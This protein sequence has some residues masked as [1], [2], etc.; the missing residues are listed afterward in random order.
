MLKIYLVVGLLLVHIPVGAITLEERIEN[1]SRNEM[2][3]VIEFL[4]HDLL[5]GRSPGT[6]GG[7]LAEAYIKSL[8][9]L[10]GLAPGFASSYLQPLHLLAFE[11]ETMRAEAGSVSLLYGKNLVGSYTGKNTRYTHRADAVFVG[12]GIQ[13]EP[14][15]WDDFKDFDVR[16]KIIIVRVNDPGMHDPSIFEGKTLTYYGRWTYHVQE[17]ARRGASGILLIHTDESAGY[18]WNVVVNSWSGEQV[19]LKSDLGNNLVWRAWITEKALVEVLQKHGIDIHELYKKSEQRDFKPVPLGF[20]F[21][22]QGR[23]R[24][25]RFTVNNVVARIPGK[26]DRK[27]V[28]SAHIDHLGIKSGMQG[29]NIFN[30]AIDN[31]SAVASMVLTGKILNEHRDRLK[32]SVDLLAC[33]AEEH[34]LLGSTF[35]VRNADRTKLVT[36]INFESTPVWDKAASI[37]AVGGGFS[38]LGD[39]V[40][41]LALRQG[42]KYS[43]FSMVEQGFFYRSDQF[44][45]ARYGI[46]SIWLSA[47]ED[48]ASGTFQYARYWKEHYHTVKD[49]YD[50]TWKLESMR[51]T[52]QSAV[53]LVHAVHR[54]K[55]DPQWKNNLTFPIV[56]DR[57]SLD[58]SK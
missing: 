31:A 5:E 14:W 28:L 33:Q 12:Y 3:A 43:T 15:N 1:I 40:R 58:R 24:S 11:V 8:F 48:D 20:S 42:L 56:S 2:Q 32:Y 13:A 45:F 9:K 44:P 30:G 7:Y 51:Q 17:A 16:N 27:I 41:R 25:R 55:A 18:G 26:S 47:G 39:M 57:P 54:S 4:S 21:K 29:D 35:Y 46:P 23:N 10:M 19:Y 34:G 38:S 22:V 37:M 49:E 36:N 53:R 52:I 50:P 6:R